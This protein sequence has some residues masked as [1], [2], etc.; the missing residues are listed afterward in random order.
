[1]YQAD[2]Y[3]YLKSLDTLPH[4]TLLISQ[5]DLEAKSI[6]DISSLLKIESFVLPDIRVSYG[7]DLRTYQDDI[8]ELLSSI[9]AYYHSTSSRKL[10]ITP[11]RTLLFN[12]PKEEYFDKIKIEF[13]SS[14]DINILKDKLYR[15]GYTFVDIAS[16]KGEVSFR[17]DIIDIYPIN[18]KLPFRVILFD[19]EVESIR[20]YNLDTQKS[21]V[22]ELESFDI[23]PAF[24]A[25]DENEFKSLNQR[26]E[27]SNFDIF[28]R[29]INSVGLWCLDDLAH[30]YIDKFNSIFTSNMSSELEEIYLLDTPMIAQN[31]FQLPTIPKA[32]EFKDIEVADINK[33]LEA[34]ESKKISIIARTQ[35]VARASNLS[36]FNNIN[37]IYQDGIV[38]IMSAREIILSI[39]KPIKAKQV[40]R[41]SIVLDEL[42]QGD[43]VVHENHG[44]GNFRSVERREIL[45]SKREFV[46]I[47]Y[48][49]DDT[50]LVPVENLET[51]DRFVADGGSVPTVD[52]LGKVSFKRLRGK[53]KDKLFAI[54]SNII[55]LSAQRHLKKGIVLDS[56]KI[57][58]KNFL[59]QAPFT[60]TLDQK[61]AIEDMLEELSGG[62]MMDRLLSADVGFGK[63]EVAMNAMFVSYI[64]GYQSMMIVP[65]TLLSS[66]HLKSLQE[67]FGNYDIKIAKIDRFSSAKEK[68]EI[69]A[70]LEDGS[71]D[72][73]VGT[74]SLL[75]AKFK[76]LALVIID[77]EHK[78][79]VKQKEVLKEI[80]IDSHLLSMSATP[81]PR[82]LNL[83]LSKIKSFSE[84]LTPPTQRQGVRTF[85]KSYNDKVIKEA[86][87]RERRRGGQL[88]YV[89]NSIATIEDKK[90]ELLRLI[91]NLRIAIL[92]SKIT[93]LKTEDEMMKF[94]NGEYDIMLS[95]SIVES[96]IHLPNANSMIVESSDNF[97][98][99]DLHQLRGRVGRGGKEGYCYFIVEDKEQ[100]S[101]NAKK[102][103]LALE[104][105]SELG[106]GAV[107]AFHDLEIRGGGN[108]IGEA[109]SGH[110]KQIGYSLYI[111]MLEDA[112]R[113]LSG[114]KEEKH[115]VDMK[116]SINAYINEELIPQDRLRLE[117]YRR[118]SQTNSQQEIRE[119]EIEI[120]DR[121]GKLDDITRAF[122]DMMIIKVL[123]RN[124]GDISKV[125]S[126]GE[127]I[128]I[129]FID[130]SKSREVLKANSKDDDDILKSAMS[131]F[132]KK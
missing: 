77:E 6:S 126:Y 86:I 31:K 2:I 67:R 80:S 66:Q 33:I 11:I 127:N 63:T 78:F 24:L 42:T 15:W 123:A 91:P 40:K 21:I 115:S 56:S 18:S 93:A 19:D 57:E 73:V 106:S 28:S 61:R 29:D 95:T 51:I 65:T 13:A 75:K 74:H 132:I 85:V 128:F 129:E 47:S 44:I 76:K 68:K 32:K 39:N 49:N 14:L 110:I 4:P 7:D 34:H 130:E 97:G 20:E 120:E 62:I 131:Y 112:I 45:G 105:H 114:E 108:I 23:I 26:V 103:L 64:N 22:D 48:Q 79:G 124:R 25:L 37:F 90:K 92:H 55:N 70:S 125:S 102:R 119:I 41:A 98:I 121:F 60:H 107:L 100:L 84:I 27:S 94:E 122:I 69:L 30:N 12:L 35:S 9:Y 5:N 71:I 111:K 43:F 117:I 101:T 36:S 8:F 3:E 17:G 104:T 83:A 53:V 88:F 46:V 10:L 38:N 16:S 54:A 50:L 87:L 1:M 109:Q 118:L 99:A 81:I 82:S 58:V 96:G 89:H 116:L 52:K 72:M 59:Y 113:E